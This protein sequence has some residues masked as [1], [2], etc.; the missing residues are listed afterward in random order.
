MCWD[1]IGGDCNSVSYNSATEGL[2]LNC[3][4]RKWS[5]KAENHRS[6]CSPAVFWFYFTFARFF[7]CFLM[8]GFYFQQFLDIF[9]FFLFA[10]KFELIAQ[11]HIH[12]SGKLH[13]INW[14]ESLLFYLELIVYVQC[15]CT[16]YR[17][18]I[19]TE[20]SLL[21]FRSFFIT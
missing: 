5:A 6:N 8:F 20:H 21:F 18:C 16:R 12:F 17:T 10:K 13:M 4:R 7:Y 14:I 1:Y 19:R 3:I 2:Q 9:L 11:I 15:A